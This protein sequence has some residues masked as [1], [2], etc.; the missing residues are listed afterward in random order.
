MRL[1]LAPYS[2]MK[3]LKF[4]S[5]QFDGLDDKLLYYF[6]VHYS[7]GFLLWTVVWKIQTWEVKMT[8]SLALQ[9][10]QCV[11]KICACWCLPALG[12]W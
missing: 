4:I 8:V 11:S 9:Y 1:T 5:F 12:Y 7:I 2:T 3:V 10:N 6:L